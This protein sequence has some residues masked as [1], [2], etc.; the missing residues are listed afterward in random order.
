MIYERNVACC[1]D[2]V[3]RCS[4]VACDD[5]N[6]VIRP[7][8]AQYRIQAVALAGGTDEA[9]NIPAPIFEQNL[10]HLSTDEA[11]RTGDKNVLIKMTH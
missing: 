9:S 4:Q 6:F 11:I 2:A 7:K 1:T 10:N 5:F 3:G 8:S